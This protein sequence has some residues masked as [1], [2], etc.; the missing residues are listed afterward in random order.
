MI[1]KLN[2]RPVR[3]I[4]RYDRRRK[5]LFE[6]LKRKSQGAEWD[7]LLST[8]WSLESGDSGVNHFYL[9]RAKDGTHWALQSNGL[10]IVVAASAESAELE[11]VAGR[12]I[13]MAEEYGE[14]FEMIEDEGDV[15]LD[16][17]LAAR[18]AP[19]S[20]DDLCRPG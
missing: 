13:K 10:I 19:W 11:W 2:V 7:F 9:R 6:Q 1:Q 8:E 17:L 14:G 12:M 3:A 16:E 15:D 5:K 20:D 4:S 18:D